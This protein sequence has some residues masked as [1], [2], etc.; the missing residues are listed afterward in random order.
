ME[1][2]VFFIKEELLRRKRALSRERG[3]FKTKLQQ[4]VKVFYRFFCLQIPFLALGLVFHDLN[5]K[6]NINFHDVCIRIWLK[7]TLI[8]SFLRFEYELCNYAQSN[9]TGVIIS[10]IATKSSSN[11]H[12]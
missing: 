1:N 10:F 6:N 7:I 3:T 2:R 9:I 4:S 5:M 12:R 8:S 11:A